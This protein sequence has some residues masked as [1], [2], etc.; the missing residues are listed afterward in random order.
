MQ[1]HMFYL[2]TIAALLSISF[3]TV[4]RTE[5]FRN[6]YP[7]YRHSLPCWGAVIMQ[8]GD[9]LS[10]VQTEFSPTPLF[11]GCGKTNAQITVTSATL[12]KLTNIVP[13]GRQVLTCDDNLDRVCCFHVDQ[14]QHVI[15]DVCTG[16]PS[17]LY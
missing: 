12:V 11:A 6:K 7:G 5:A 13:I 4:T 10:V 8:G 3:M 17:Q 2:T 9:S 15:T 16:M 1:R 14:R